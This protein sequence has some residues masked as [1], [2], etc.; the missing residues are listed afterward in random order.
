MKE[1]GGNLSKINK[2]LDEVTYVLQISY[3]Y[4]KLKSYTNQY[5]KI[6]LYLMSLP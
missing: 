5:T 6:S 3:R 1:N 4:L 2:T